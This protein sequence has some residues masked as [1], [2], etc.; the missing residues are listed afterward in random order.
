MS[1]SRS[2]CITP[3]KLLN[4]TKEYPQKV[5]LSIPLRQIILQQAKTPKLFSSI[6][7]PSPP[8]RP[9]LQKY[10]NNGLPLFLAEYLNQTESN[11]SSRGFASKLFSNS[12]QLIKNSSEVGSKIKKKI[13]QHKEDS[14]YSNKVNCLTPT[15]NFYEIQDSR[16]VLSGNLYK[17]YIL[18][19]SP[20][21]KIRL[22]SQSPIGIERD[23]RS[24]RRNRSVRNNYQTTVDGDFRKDT[25]A[26]ACPVFVE[27][28]TKTY[29]EKLKRV[30][31]ITEEARLEAEKLQV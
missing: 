2:N 28:Y 26:K 31:E 11:F 1:K 16:K 22:Y 3:Y 24:G 21:A 27:N 5:S 30:L 10:S 13:I 23:C 8:P 6:R 14:L 4:Q 12:K 20:R 15:P 9:S 7:P 25:E 18:K 29:A 19:I 17:P